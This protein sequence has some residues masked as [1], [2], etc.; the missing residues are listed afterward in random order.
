MVKS[1]IRRIF[2][3]LK[4]S[5]PIESNHSTFLEVEQ[6]PFF[7][8]T[9]LA[10]FNAGITQGLQLLMEPLLEVIDTIITKYG[11]TSTPVTGVSPTA[12][13]NT[14]ATQTYSMEL[15]HSLLVLLRLFN[16]IA[17]VT[18]EVY[19]QDKT[20]QVGHYPQL[21]GFNESLYT[22]YSI[23]FATEREHFHTMAP[24]NLESSNANALIRLCS[25]LKSNHHTLNILKQMACYLY[26]SSRV[27]SRI[28]HLDHSQ[29]EHAGLDVNPLLTIIDIN[30]ETI[31]KYVAASNPQEFY[32][33]I[34]LRILNPLL[35]TQMYNDTDVAQYL[36][37]FSFY[38]VTDK[39]LATFL[40][41][42]AKVVNNF[43]KSVYL[44]ALLTFVSH[45]MTIWI[46]SRPREYLDVVD[47]VRHRPDELYTQKII[48]ESSYLFEEIYATFNVASILMESP[49]L[50]GN[51][52]TASTPTSGS[53]H[54]G[55]TDTL[56]PAKPLSANSL[57]IMNS[58]NTTIKPFDDAGL[59]NNKNDA[60]EAF[61]PYSNISNGPDCSE[62]M[63]N[64][65]VLRFL[66]CMIMLHPGAF[67]E[68]NSTSFKN[69]P[70]EP[71]LNEY[72]L[73]DETSQ[74]ISTTTSGSASL[75]SE[76][77]KAKGVQHRRLK[78]L[79]KLASFPSLTTSNH[80]VKFLTTLL[81]NINGTQIV[82][83]N[84]LLDTLRTLILISRL[85]VSLILHDR[86]TFVTFFSRRLF[87]VLCDSLQISNE[88]SA[89]R[90]PLIVKCLQAHKVAHMKLQVEYFPVA[91]SLEP[92]AFNIKLNEYLGQKHE[93]L[94]HLKMITEG[95]RV[96]F[97]LPNTRSSKHEVLFRAIGLLRKAAFE[98]SDVIIKGSPLFD[99]SISAAIDNLCD[100]SVVCDSNDGGMPD[101]DSPTS[102][103]FTLFVPRD[104]PENLS[105]TP[106][107]PSFSSASSVHSEKQQ[108]FLNF[109]PNRFEIEVPNVNRPAGSSSSNLLVKL[110]SM[111]TSP[112]ETEKSQY[113]IRSAMDRNIR[114]PLR[115][116]SRLRRES[117]DCV[118]PV[119]NYTI[120]TSSESA[121]NSKYDASTLQTAR[122]I[123]V[124]VYSIY[125][126]MMHYFLYFSIA[127]N[128]EI[129]QTDRLQEFVKPLYVALFE[130]S[131]EVHDAVVSYCDMGISYIS[132]TEEFTAASYMPLVYRLS[133][134]LVTLLS[135]TLFNLSLSDEKRER[136]YSY[137][138]TYWEFRL[139]ILKR[140]D[141]AGE[142]LALKDE[143]MMTFPLIHGATGRALFSSLYSHD[144]RIHKLLKIG[145]K[146]F[147]KELDYHERI[148]Q[149]DC[150]S[151]Y[152]NKEFIDAM[153]RDSYVAI[154]ALAFQRRLRSDILAYV[155]YPN[156]IL[157]DSLRLIYN[158]WYFMSKEKNLSQRELTNFRNFAGFIATSCGV[159]LTNDTDLLARFPY[160]A[161][162]RN[163]VV[164]KI[165]YFIYKQCQCINNEDLLTR[166]NSKDIISTELH[167]LAFATL[168]KHLKKKISDLSSVDVTLREN[169]LSFVLLEQII[170]ILRV[171]MERDDEM[172]VLICVSLDLVELIEEIFKIIEQ[173]PHDSPKYYKS[174]IQ[175]CKML[176]SF[177][178]SEESVCISGYMLIKNKWLRLTIQWFEIT[179]LKEY[180]LENLGKPHRSM[181]LQRRD[182]DYL[183]IDTSIESSKA[184]A[185]LTKELVLEAPQSMSEKELSRSKEV[186]FGNYFNILLKG[187]EK[188]TGIKKFP[189]TL[190]HKIG[191]LN[192]NIITSLTNILNYNVDVGF[193]YAL[194]IGYSPNRNIK[195]AFLKVFVNIV[196]N[197]D[198]S[199]QKLREQSNEAIDRLTI[200][201][202]EEP[203]LISK[204]VRVCPANDIDALA[205]SLVTIYNVKNV[206]HLLVIELIRDEISRATRY[207]DVLR[208]NS[209]ATRA[210]SM[211]SRLKGGAYLINVLKPVL[212]EVVSTGE[213]FDVEKIP[214]NDLDC[215]RNVLLFCKYMSKLVDSIVNSVEDFP[216]EFFA[217]CQAIYTSVKA[218]FPDSAEIAVGS[219]IFLRFFCPSLVSPDSEG[220][221]DTFNPKAR[222]SFMILAKVIQN[223]ANGSVSSLKWPALQNEAEFLRLISDRIFCFLREISA[224][225]RK[226]E[227]HT[228]LENKVTVDEF[229]L[230]HKYLYYHG[231]DIR[232]EFIN[233][234]KSFEDLVRLKESCKLTDNLLSLLGQPRMEFK[235]AIPLYIRENVENN[236]ELYDFM[237]RHSLKN[238]RVED[239]P[240]V[241]EAVSPDGFPIVI[242]T[243]HQCDQV[244]GGDVD[245]LMYRVFQIYSKLWTTKH[246]CVADCTGFDLKK[247]SEARIKKILNLFYKLV[248]IE[249][250]KNCACFYYLNVTEQYLNIWLPIVK[251]TSQYLS[252][253]NCPHLF[254]NS[255]SSL[256][257]IK[258]LTLSEFSSEVCADVRVTLHDASLY[259]EVRMRF[260]PV[261]LKIGNKHFQMIHDTPKRI[262]IPTWDEVIEVNYNEVFEIS[263]IRS[264]GVSTEVGVPYELFILMEDGRKLTLCSPRYLEILKIFYYSQTRLED[265]YR[266]DE[267]SGMLSISEG[268]KPKGLTYMIGHILMVVFV[269][270]NSEDEA[271]EAV[272]YNLL[273]ATQS[274]FELDYGHRLTLSPE[275]YVP[276]DNSAFYTSVLNGLAVSA[277]ELSECIWVYSL[278]MLENVLSE[279][280]IPILLFAL[281]SWTKNLYE[282]VYLVDDEEGPEITAQIVRRLIR[283][284]AKHETHS[285]IYAQFVW[286]NFI[287][288][289]D[290]VELI[291]EELIHHCVDRDSEGTE[292]KK[293]LFILTR[294]PTT[295]V[296]GL[297][298]NKI[299]N[300][301]NSFLPTLTL[302]ASTHS[303]SELIISVEMAV[304]LFF[305]SLLL[306]QMYL[307][308]VLCIVSLLID[309]GPTE[310]RSAL[311]RLLMNVCQSF[312]NDEMLS[313]TNKQN[314]DTVSN[315]FSRQKLKFMFGFSQ[316]KGRVLQNFSASS[317]LTKFTTLEYFINNMLMLIDNASLTDS[318]FWKTK[319]VKYVLDVVSNVESFLSSR[320]MMIMGIVA[321]SGIKDGLCRKLLLHTMKIMGAPWLTE[322]LLFYAISHV[323]AYTKMVGG[324]D[325]TSNLVPQLFWLATAFV[326]S[327]NAML[328][329]GGLLLMANSA[330]RLCPSET[331]SRQ[332]SRSIVK[333]LY[334]QRAFARGII[335]DIESVLH[336]RLTEANFDH[337]LIYF[338][339]KGLLVPLVRSTSTETLI[340]FFK[341]SY[342]ELPYH[343]NNHYLVYMLFVFLV[344]RPDH[345]E[346]L[347][348]K[349]GLKSQMVY[350]DDVTK[351]NQ[352]LLDWLKSENENATIALYQCALYFTSRNADEPSKLRFL[353]LLK[354]LASNSPS[355]VFK[356]Y[357]II[358]EELGRINAYDRT[359]NTVGVAFFVIRLMVV[360]RDYLKLDDIDLDMKNFLEQKGLTGISDIEFETAT[361]DYMSLNKLQAEKL[362]QR[363]QQ[364]V[365]IIN[366]IILSGD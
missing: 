172:D 326:R 331:A 112:S 250:A 340:T 109:P 177:E 76:E 229:H 118:T 344:Q 276:A 115:L 297:V 205:S 22:K 151:L 52:S 285:L 211:F 252:H 165:D 15:L 226:L 220:I 68:I 1:L 354:Y 33:Y 46:F 98:M 62:R 339:S 333:Y 73:R 155:K 315:I 168:F 60:T 282:H 75:N 254:V 342:N 139:D 323:F 281:S 360:Q 235:S 290:L 106:S 121:D 308:E 37:S 196:S 77:A 20:P 43:K 149:S 58:N 28:H 174:I 54:S 319:Y 270:L 70:D 237:S 23:G 137:V 302:E 92:D 27:S 85:S 336:I 42:T 365:K 275:V 96:F 271:V 296:C 67:E 59:H 183:Y 120:V 314:I 72:D 244:P 185:Y 322:D 187:L 286:S 309:V 341:I 17:Q 210:L 202:I 287:L 223:I 311:H 84:S 238:L 179:I 146:L 263:N 247:F 71:L 119:S 203:H 321:T 51:A 312:A 232:R 356:V 8:N 123:L 19:E 133:G 113:S 191:L 83:D 366:R 337:V 199:R 6:E 358:R 242:F 225:N 170:L 14:S 209:C 143:N 161:D 171:I 265:E 343:G 108:P 131:S 186:V 167:P 353:L 93:G 241:R 176:R 141:Q 86:N 293:V 69:L 204:A 357:P 214:P 264:T 193:K 195:L 346:R 184:L 97:S 277:P 116:T 180:D 216:P 194:P 50:H 251:S 246:Y 66:S 153:C 7:V 292:W 91:C 305:D 316:D 192:E 253:M 107:I 156:R 329:Q 55:V 63:T 117:Q 130:D 362:Y 218:K 10:L 47:D 152:S 318:Y 65:A 125:R 260:T 352:C 13:A 154:S 227:I 81:R 79:K 255:S 169:K 157:Y 56:S 256:K 21:P 126:D 103:F 129:L 94:Q 104:A 134:Y 201:A 148:T 267:P 289:G 74:T 164:D 122:E 190:R 25:S 12:G 110:A 279:K 95:Y 197:F 231:L 257:S 240:F 147:A 208:R 335:E 272:A 44:E 40:D 351:I 163:S 207:M 145:F 298:V 189:P 136:L 159:F 273:A 295:A 310:L 5:L 26:R 350:L 18:W 3:Q 4:Q 328:Y 222:R 24:P 57:A 359:S 200:R 278:N 39:N 347:V 102:E 284:T 9:R 291:F 332:E 304:S 138:T 258:K 101:I 35:V 173:I 158:R 181:D 178:H 274:T 80:R 135:A 320:A 334:E 364:L 249:A 182:L 299:R 78:S 166:E 236:P 128:L 162:V 221:I 142:L 224:P 300:I 41:I 239:T 31:M 262:K 266:E 198:I 338:I 248:P 144:P 132:Q 349:V 114:S 280:Q 38:F 2:S 283:L 89:K 61:P 355:M 88:Q 245:I 301:C 215:N 348:N 36:D 124:N 29:Y 99:D 261:T 64:I 268:H 213:I 228:T 11:P 48:K 90:N 324:L 230:I 330:K 16:D 294:I 219:F 49:A 45:A 150:F 105:Q 82:S 34:N 234:I 233:D 206:G 30:C 140:F 53:A 363:K 307:P 212:D 32:N 306:S 269:G 188:S 111:S 259:D 361:N 313:E 160:L 345:Y 217:I 317:F 303:W 100:Y 243:W 327:P 325:P 87:S 175:I 288:E 127:E